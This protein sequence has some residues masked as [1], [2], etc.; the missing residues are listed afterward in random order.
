[1]ELP[2]PEKKEL[3]FLAMHKISLI[4]PAFYYFNGN[5]YITFV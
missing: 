1:M 2:D 4:N 3:L 5:Q